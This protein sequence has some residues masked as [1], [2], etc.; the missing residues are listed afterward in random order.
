MITKNNIIFIYGKAASFKS[1]IG[2][3]LINNCDNSCYI[4][5][6]G[7]KHIKVNEN[8]K[9]ITCD[10]ININDLNFIKNSIKVYDTILIDYIHLLDIRKEE[11]LELIDLVRKNNKTLIIIGVCSSNKEL[12][13]NNNYYEEIKNITDLIILTEK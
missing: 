13:S 9:V 8:V 2:V 10:D 5:L 6:E 12:I 1:T 11:L 3:S 4:N 7:N